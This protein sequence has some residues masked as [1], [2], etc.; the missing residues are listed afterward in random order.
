MHSNPKLPHPSNVDYKRMAVE[1]NSISFL[2]TFL[3]ILFLF[4]HIMQIM[5]REIFDKT[6]FI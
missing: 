6:Q 4:M 3:S 5:D 2:L 1:K